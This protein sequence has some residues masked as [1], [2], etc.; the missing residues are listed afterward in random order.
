MGQAQ[1]GHGYYKG[2]DDA[3]KANLVT[4]RVTSPILTRRGILPTDAIIRASW[5]SCFKLKGKLVPLDPIA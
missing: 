5:K 3:A 4:C 1:W 2:M